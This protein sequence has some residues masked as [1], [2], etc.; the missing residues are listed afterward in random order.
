MKDSTHHPFSLKVLDDNLEIN[1]LSNTDEKIV[2]EMIN[3]DAPVVNA[4][5]RIMIAEVQ[6]YNLIQDS[7][8]G[9]S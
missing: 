3:I 9:N 1:V 7:N 6:I 2:F 5:R 4:L 8:N